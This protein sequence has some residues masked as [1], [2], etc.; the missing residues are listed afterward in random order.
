MN[1]ELD[2]S[3]AVAHLRADLDLAA[4]AGKAVNSATTIAGLAAALADLEE[5]PAKAEALATAIGNWREPAGATR[6][7]RLREEVGADLRLL[8]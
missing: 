6:H 2:E 7:R 5:P 1:V 4:A 8:R 3:V